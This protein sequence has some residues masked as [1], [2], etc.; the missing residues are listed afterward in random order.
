MT[1][2]DWLQTHC[3]RLMLR[4]L[5]VQAWIGIHDFEKAASQR[6]RVDVDVYVLLTT[7]TPVADHITEVIDYDFVR[8]AVHA[9]IARGPIGLQET[10]GDEL[11]TTLLAHPA[12]VAARVRTGKP[13]VYPDCDFVGV[14]TFRFR[15]IHQVTP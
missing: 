8:E 10:L 5:E 2:L 6:L 13:D 12:V 11:L 3:R 9:R 1:N 4:G 14:E 15:D 7:S